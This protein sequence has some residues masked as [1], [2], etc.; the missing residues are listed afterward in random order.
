MAK[1]SYTLAV[2]LPCCL[3]VLPHNR[4]MRPAQCM[5]SSENKSFQPC[6]I[7]THFAG[8]GELLCH[9]VVSARV[10]IVERVSADQLPAATTAAC[11]SARVEHADSGF[12]T[13]GPARSRH[14]RALPNNAV[15]HRA[16]HGPA[17]QGAHHARSMPASSTQLASSACH[18]RL[19]PHR[20]FRP[21][22]R[23][24]PSAEPAA[25]EASAPHK[26]QKTIVVLP[27]RRAAACARMRA[28]HRRVDEVADAGHNHARYERL[29]H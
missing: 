6:S 9:H 2:P 28:P 25:H 18:R 13:S 29:R 5:I 11:T 15:Q 26:S 10:P 14:F 7:A 21:Y 4:V 3:L 22:H 17:V 12:T 8:R 16:L 24:S 20:L 27:L 1:N 19:P 23:L